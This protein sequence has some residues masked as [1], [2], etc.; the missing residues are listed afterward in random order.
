V[1]YFSYVDV[2]PM[3]VLSPFR[4]VY[5]K[6]GASCTIGRLKCTVPQYP[7]SSTEVVS[8]VVLRKP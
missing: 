8:K 2:H 7:C 1:M 3:L 5:K 4:V 6:S